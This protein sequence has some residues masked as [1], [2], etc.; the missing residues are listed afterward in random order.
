MTDKSAN[1]RGRPIT[2]QVDQ[3]PASPEDIAKAL[4][5]AADKKLNPVK[6]KPN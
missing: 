6:K 4:F 1:P 5:R 2:N 3:I